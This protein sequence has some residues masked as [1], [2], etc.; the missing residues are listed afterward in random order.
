[1]KKKTKQ[2]IREFIGSMMVGLAMA[3]I[4][5]AFLVR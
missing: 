5:I 1:M 4:I 2:N 3:E